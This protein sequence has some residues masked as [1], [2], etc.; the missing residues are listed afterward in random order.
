MYGCFACMNVH[1]PHVCR[2]QKRKSNLLGLELWLLAAMWVLGIE[3]EF[4][5]RTAT[6]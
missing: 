2:G 4:S 6:T 1:V 5:I 3:P